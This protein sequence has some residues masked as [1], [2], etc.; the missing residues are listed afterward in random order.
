MITK[1]HEKGVSIYLS[2]VIMGILLS[3]AL[4]LNSI[5]LGQINITQEVANSVVAFYAAETG[6]ER[7]LYTNSTTTIT[8]SGSLG[9]ASYIVQVATTTAPGCPA[10]LSYCVT[11]V[12]TYKTTN[13]AIYLSR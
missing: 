7:E 4:G 3:L 12:G 5:L 9:D 10:P 1:N 8:Y 6:I 13:R 11:S 2:L